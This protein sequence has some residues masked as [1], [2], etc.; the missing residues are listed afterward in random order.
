M[1]ITGTDG[2]T[3]YNTGPTR[4]RSTLTYRR[5]R[6]RPLSPLWSGGLQ[7]LPEGPTHI[8]ALSLRKGGPRRAPQ[9]LCGV[10]HSAR[11]VDQGSVIKPISLPEVS[12]F[13]CPFIT[14]ML[15]RRPRGKGDLWEPHHP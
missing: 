10:P 5:M 4:V 9:R 11:Q 6:D 7:R 13:T 3:A 1:A 8:V 12:P 14:G 15:M 2:G